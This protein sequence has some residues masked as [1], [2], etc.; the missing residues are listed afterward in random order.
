MT[1]T[2][3]RMSRIWFRRGIV[4]GV[5]TFLALFFATKFYYANVFHGLNPTWTKQLWWQ[6]MEW[7]GWAFFPPAIFLVCRRLDQPDHRLRQVFS[8]LA[9]GAVF[10]LFHCFILTTGARIE[11]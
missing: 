6:S 5:A 3:T 10:S 2:A 9:A 4:F 11:A 8:H 7:Y 1:S